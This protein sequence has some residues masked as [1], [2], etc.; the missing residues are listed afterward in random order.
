LLC[1]LYRFLAVG[2]LGGFPALPAVGVAE[3]RKAKLL[4]GF[5]IRLAMLVTLV[6]TS[7]KLHQVPW[8]V[9][10]AHFQ[11]VKATMDICGRCFGESWVRI[12]PARSFSS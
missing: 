5:L 8:N 3:A 9:Q 7:T 12:P 6:V 2:R 11:H 1:N 4:R 10:L